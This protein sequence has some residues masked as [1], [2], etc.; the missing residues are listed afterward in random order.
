[1][2]HLS[3]EELTQAYYRDEEPE[4]R[5]HLDECALCQ[6]AFQHLKT[7]LD[8]LLAEPVPERGA[9]Y[10]AEVW[11]RLLPRLPLEKPRRV[12]LRWWTAV[13][14]LAGLLAIAFLAGRFTGPKTAGIAPQARQRILLITLGN[15]LDQSEILL[16]EVVN[17]APEHADF[18]NERSSA[19]DLLDENRLLRQ[20]AAR[21]GDASHAAVL[22]EL[23]RTLLDIAHSPTEIT[24]AEL[25]SLQRRIE[26][27]GLLFKVRVISSNIHHQG[28]QL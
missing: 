26:S 2:N 4:S 20:T 3:E 16:A 28:Q 8:E 12:W 1:M 21:A 10:G 6:A 27:E 11:N 5:R 23:E 24:P 13:P 22:D 14:V 19:Q 7:L 25:E 18:S 15:H 17:A 9:D